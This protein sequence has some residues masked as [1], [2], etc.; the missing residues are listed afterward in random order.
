M[1]PH[2]FALPTHPRSGRAARELPAE[3]TG[4]EVV[5]PM[6]NSR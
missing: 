2:N 1:I 4:F 3:T 6:H 5:K